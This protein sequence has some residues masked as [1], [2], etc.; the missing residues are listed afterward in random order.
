MQASK[1]ELVQ[2]RHELSVQLAKPPT[3]NASPAAIGAGKQGVVSA[4]CAMLAV[5]HHAPHP[6]RLL[7]VLNLKCL[8]SL[9]T[10]SGA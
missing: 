6:T 9:H 5:Y 8:H 2:F 7:N 4:V 3:R 10:L 1:Q